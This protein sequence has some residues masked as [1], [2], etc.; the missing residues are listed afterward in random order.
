M[1][2]G[3]E[4]GGIRLLESEKDGKPAFNKT[5]LTFR[6]HNNAILDIT[7]SSDDLL[8]ATASGDQTAQIIDMPTQRTTHTLAGHV[9][10]VKQIR[11]QPESNSKVIAT[12]SRDGSIQLWDLRCKGIERPV[13]EIKAIL[14]GTVSSSATSVSSTF[15][16]TYASC[17]NM[18]QGAHDCSAGVFES[19]DIASGI[20]GSSKRQPKRGHERSEVSITS[21]S[22]LP[23]SNPYLLLS[24]SEAHATVRLWDLRMNQSRRQRKAIPVCTTRQPDSH[25]THRQFGLTSLV[26]SG[27]G[28]RL[29]TLCKDN[30]VYAY[31]T[32]HLV[33]GTS[34]ELEHGSL[35]KP[36]RGLVEKEGLGPIYGFRHAKLKASTF[37]VK[38]ALR[39]AQGSKSEMLA[40]GSTD[41]CAV[42]FPTN[43]QYL[44]HS[45][46]RTKSLLPSST[47]QP[48]ALGLGAEWSPS[49]RSSSFDP[50]KPR[51]HDT[52]PIYDHGLALVRG[53]DKE[54]TSISWSCDGELITVGDDR[55]CRVWREDG[56]RARELRT[57]GEASGNRWCHG[58]AELGIGNDDW[59]Q[60]D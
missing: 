30:T 3:D 56:Q 20:F 37:Y 42:L 6:P 47:P 25:G 22:F 57:I 19:L 18:I 24:G 35:V 10:S 11:F 2:I 32:S 59:D 54:V 46:T 45:K 50:Q 16:M 60:D 28:A 52:I 36:R 51:L 40:V 17:V 4:E 41:S 33:L 43:E 58:W 27:D 13:S 31:S 39:P 7:F 5:Y 21:L 38:L 14:G 55:R 8:M 34:P 9:S 26:L 44:H 15:K 48:P 29:F 53:H 49:E 23:H 12:S 1:A